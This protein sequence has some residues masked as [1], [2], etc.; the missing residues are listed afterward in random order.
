M[1]EVS[2][3]VFVSLAGLEPCVHMRVDVVIALTI[4]NI[5]ESRQ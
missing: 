2:G 4:L 1:L 3:R 5:V